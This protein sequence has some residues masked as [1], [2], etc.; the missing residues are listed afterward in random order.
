ME[1]IKCF[2]EF[3]IGRLREGQHEF[4][5]LNGWMTPDRARHYFYSSK[6]LAKVQIILRLSTLLPC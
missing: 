2:S 5:S 1:I 4:S 6:S 3:R